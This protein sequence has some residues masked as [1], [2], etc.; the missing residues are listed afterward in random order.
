MGVDSDTVGAR[1]R[2]RSH[3]ELPHLRV[4]QSTNTPRRGVREY[5]GTLFAKIALKREISADPPLEFEPR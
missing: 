2:P 3:I 5:A 4:R 1:L